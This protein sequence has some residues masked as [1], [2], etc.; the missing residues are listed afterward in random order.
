MTLRPAAVSEVVTVTAR[1]DAFTNTV[2][3]LDQHPAGAAR[4]AAD[5]ADDPVGGEPRAGRARDRPEQRHHHRRRDVVR[6]SVH[7]RRRADPGQHARHAVLALHRGRDSGNDGLDVRHLGRVR[8]V[9]RRRRQRDHEVWA[10]T[11]SADRS[12]RRS[13]TTTGGR[14]SPFDEPKIERTVPTYEFTIGGP[15]VRNRTWFFGAGRFFDQSRPT[16]R[17]TRDPPTRSTTT[18]SGSRARSR[19]RSGRATTYAAPTP[20]SAKPKPTTS[21]RARRKC[22]DLRSLHTRQMPQELLSLHYSGTLKS[23]LFVEAQYSARGSSPS[24]TPA[25]RPTD[26]IEGTVLRSQ[27]TGAFWWSPNFCGVCGPEERDNNNLFLKSTYFLST[28]RIA[29]HGVRLR[30]LQRQAQ[31]RQ[32]SVRQRLSRVG[33]PIRSSRTARSTR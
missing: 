15:I 2:A 3:G 11:T 22:I 8:P 29:Q 27:Q 32:P 28:A 25:A 10:A 23:N 21:G 9:H 31:G 30:H 1:T 5:G 4:D 20:P 16:R 6:Q 12:G 33:P 26:M 19:S 17:A 24:R 18:R 7:A 14:S 13:P